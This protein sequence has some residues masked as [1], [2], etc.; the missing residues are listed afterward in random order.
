MD[1]D[2]SKG[3]ENA[4]GWRVSN[5]ELVPKHEIMS[6]DEIADL[7]KRYKVKIEQLPKLLVTDPVAKEIGAEVGDIVKVT[8]KSPTTRFSVA[9]RLVVL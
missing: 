6:Q 1:Q 2:T 9:Y 8:R 7:L 4:S 3:K 5:H